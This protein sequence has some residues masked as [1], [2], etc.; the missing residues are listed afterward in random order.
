MTA[1][2]KLRSLPFRNE[3]AALLV[4]LLVTPLFPRSVP[5]GLYVTGFAGASALALNA[6]AIVLVYRANR[7]A[8]FAQLQLVAFCAVVFGAL[9]QGQFFLNMTRSVCGCVS[10]RPEGLSVTINFVLAIIVAVAVGAIL[11]FGFYVTLLRR[12]SHAPRLMLTL[13]TVFAAQALDSSK[14]PVREWFVPP[15]TSPVTLQERPTT[16]P[17]D[18]EWRIDRFTSLHSGD[19]IL[20]LLAVVGIAAL[21]RYLRKSD[22]GVAIRAASESPDRARTLGIDVVA[23]TSRVWLVGGIVAGVTGVV[24]GFGNG[25][26]SIGPS[27]GQMAIVLLVAILAKFDSFPMVAVAAA[28]LGVVRSLVPFSFGSS[29]PLEAALV[30]LM[31][32][33]LL[34]QRYRESRADREDAT[35]FE[36]TREVRPIPKEL[37]GLPQVRAWVRNGTAVGVLLLLGIPWALPGSETSV[38]TIYL[39]FAVVGLS[40]LVVTGWAGQVSLG[41]F[42][43]ATIGAWGAAVSGLPMPAAVLVGGLVGAAAAVVVGLPALRLKG[44]NLAISTLAFAVSASALFTGDRYLGGML[45]K[46]LERPNLLGMDLE[47]SRVFYYAM[48]AVVAATAFAVVGL[49][50]SRTGRTL[51]ALRAN[52]AAAQS[53]GVN[54]LRLRLTAFAISGFLAALAGGLFAFHQREVNAASFT[55]EMSLI[56]FTFAVIGGL[57]GIAGPFFGFGFMALLEFTKENALIS[58]FA[59][60]M[61]G[62]LILMAAPGGLSQIAYDIRD[63]ALRRLAVRLRIPVPSLMGDRAAARTFDRAPLDD[64]RGGRSRSV[65][66]LRYRLPHQWALDAYAAGEK[67]R[68]RVPAAIGER[69]AP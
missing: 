66:P 20:L 7:F 28:V 55:P 51:I 60:G 52:E 4:L 48:L 6:V 62:M 53:F 57:G 34:L 31:G 14:Q 63:A 54:A 26:Q 36:I 59:G 12:F 22:T 67:R 3:L 18:F 37:R 21:T 40:I 38:L 50:R 65:L 49:R 1:V 15:D 47:D 19:I 58:Y 61:G 43:F 32:G 16:P 17:W 64:Q 24:V 44:L 41:Q 27:M 23:V 13:F 29:A 56:T 42:G 35:G 30:F 33:L 46:A 39:I 2:M 25:A 69:G 10:R 5:F 9:V 8:N 11:S 45:P 68:E